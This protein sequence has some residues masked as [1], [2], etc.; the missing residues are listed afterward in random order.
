MN[1]L[2]RVCVLAPHTDDGEFG[3]GASIAQW[4]HEGREVHYIAFSAC[5]TSV[6]DGWPEDVLIGEMRAATSVLGLPPECARVL[7][8]EVRR[9][10]SSRQEILQTLVDLDVELRPDLVLMPTVDDL[11]QDHHVVATEALRA[12]KR[13]SILAYEIPWNNVQFRSAG[14]VEVSERSAQRKC[15]A[16][17]CY[18]SQGQRS[19]SDEEFLRAQMRFRGVQAG[20]RY[21]E[22]F[23][24][25]RWIL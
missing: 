14:F 8:F 6:P 10:A 20:V 22:A 15:E 21:A 13:R 25:I 4:V 5:Q 1:A 2:S 17:A 3:A 11:H 7:D 24:V 18:A 9:F 16:I 19:Y 12:F 23:D